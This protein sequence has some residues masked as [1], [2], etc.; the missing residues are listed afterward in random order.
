MAPAMLVSLQALTFCPVVAKA[1][2][3]YHTDEAAADE[4]P[5]QVKKQEKCTDV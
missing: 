5:L 4:N 2:T 3:R 1:P